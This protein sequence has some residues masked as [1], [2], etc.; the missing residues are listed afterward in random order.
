M[1]AGPI[2]DHDVRTLDEIACEI[3]CCTRCPLYC[4]ATQSV[5]GEGPEGAQ[6]ML[7]GEQPGDQDVNG[8][9]KVVHWAEQN[10]AT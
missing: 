2:L 4:N 5:P 10:Q 6:I 9:V 8:G 7:V 1:P 3:R